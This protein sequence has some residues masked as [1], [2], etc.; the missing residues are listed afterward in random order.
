MSK[1]VI[2]LPDTTYLEKLASS[3]PT[4]I[5]KRPPPG[6]FAAPQPLLIPPL[7]T[8]IRFSAYLPEM[9]ESKKVRAPRLEVTWD[10]R[11]P[12]PSDDSVTLER[13]K[14]ISRVQ[15]QHLCGSCWAIG[16][17]GCVSDI[18]VF[19]GK[20]TYNPDISTTYSLSCYPQSQCFGGNPAL[21]ALNITDSGVASNA[22]VDYSWCKSND[23]CSGSGSGHFDAQNDTLMFNQSIPQCGCYSPSDH[24]LYFIRNPVTV[25]Q[26]RPDED[27]TGVIKTHIRTYG[28]VL[29]GYH[30]L[31]NFMGGNFAKTRGVYIENVNYESDDSYFLTQQSPFTGSHAVCVI[32]WG[33]EKAIRVKVNGKEEVTDVP[34]WYV[35]N[36][37]GK[38][39]GMDN[40]FFKMAMYPYNNISQFE[41]SVVISD[42][43]GNFESGGFIMF[44]AGNIEKGA[45]QKIENPGP[46]IEQPPFYATEVNVNKASSSNSK[47]L[48][49]DPDNFNVIVITSILVVVLFVVVY[50]SYSK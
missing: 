42:S 37:W 45:F 12:Y 50:T 3:K 29:A 25:T 38:E 33:I 35:R 20:T 18:F 48:Y 49:K 8:D 46:L 2:K 6:T 31:R 24:L 44:E 41:M 4:K 11:H 30:V 47:K 9:P 27:V 40:G 43:K 28:T 26:Q 34:Y 15:N 22:C 14:N 32:G 23:K 7:N 36:S 5:I 1:I 17:A 16:M 39:W 10:W 13:K 19:S 21:L